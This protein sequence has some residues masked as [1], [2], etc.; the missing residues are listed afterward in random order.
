MPFLL[1]MDG[2]F[3]ALHPGMIR[4]LGF[5]ASVEHPGKKRR[6]LWF[7]MQKSG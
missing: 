5:K 1:L 2:H 4:S 7:K 3:L 6:R